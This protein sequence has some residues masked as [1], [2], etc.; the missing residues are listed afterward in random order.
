MVF[1]AKTDLS[2]LQCMVATVT[3][4]R[5]LEHHHHHVVLLAIITPFYERAKVVLLDPD[6]L[7][8]ALGPRSLNFVVFSF[9]LVFRSS[10]R[11]EF[12]ATDY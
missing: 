3:Q 2:H 5:K 11:L 4:V 1:R 9:L 7:F 6:L 10:N 12:E 8:F